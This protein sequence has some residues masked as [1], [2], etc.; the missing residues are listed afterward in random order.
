M[1]VSAERPRDVIVELPWS[2]PLDDAPFYAFPGAIRGPSQVL[3]MWT[4]EFDAAAKLTG[5]FM[6]VCHPRYSGRPARILALER[7]VDHIES[8]AGIWFARCDD[9]ATHVRGHSSTPLYAAPEIA[10]R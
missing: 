9:V 4:E 8:T 2:W 3:D 6:V 7:L 5:F 10:P 1:Q